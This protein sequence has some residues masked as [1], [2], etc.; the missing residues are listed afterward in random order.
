MRGRIQAITIVTSVAVFLFGSGVSAALMSPLSLEHEQSP[1]MSFY[2]MKRCAALH[3][4]VGQMIKNAQQDGAAE[5]GKKHLL[6]SSFF[7]TLAVDT[8]LRFGTESKV[9]Y[10]DIEGIAINY[11]K[12]WRDNARATGHNFDPV[13]VDD[14]DYCVGFLDRLNG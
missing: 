6:Y 8:G 5:A 13:T 1:A 14:L 3:L 4:G 12:M 11:F 10:E 7:Q 9:V 2:R